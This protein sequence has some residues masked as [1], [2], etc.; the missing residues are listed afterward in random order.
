MS[1]WTDLTV[2]AAQRP[3]HLGLLTLALVAGFMLA[4][5]GAAQDADEGAGEADK[6]RQRISVE[7]NTLELR[8]SENVAIFEGDVEAK[9]GELVLNADTLTVYY[10]E[11]EG[12]Q[13]NLG[14]SRIDAEGNVFVSSPNETAQGQRGVYDVENGRIDLAGDVVLK[15]GNNVVKGETLTMDLESGVSLVSG[16]STRVRSLF[17]PVDDDQ[18]TEVTAD[19]LEVRQ[20]ENV[21]I[22]EGDVEAKQGELVLNADTLTVHY[23]EGEGSQ[24]NLGISRIDAE[25]NVFVSSP[26]EMAQGQRGV[27]DVE[28]G[29][30][31]LAGDVVLNQGNNVV[32]GETLTMDLESGV[33]LVS[34]GSTR[35]RSLFVP[36]DDDQ[37]TEVTA[38]TLEVRQLENVAIFEGDVEA[39]QGELVLNADTLT[40]HYREGEGSQGNLG[41]S[42]ID[43]ESNVF[44]SSPNEMAQGQRG[45]YDVENGRIDLAGD[46]VLNQGNNVVK[47]ETLTMDLESGVSLVSGGSTRVRGLFEPEDEEE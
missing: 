32:K 18:G 42:R 39:K 46:V 15:Q 9:Q 23:R 45:V 8:Q 37:G 3:T 36:V 12:S 29:R 38:D 28:N 2:P 34:G 1:I 14:V 6:A 13:G 11:S 26:N 31:D 17:V 21:A 22:F 33:S 41:I 25:S 5:A 44:V 24:G 7:A 30:I 35:V 16:G 10:R 47:G 20:L 43:A 4:N 27:Y 19:T 40:V